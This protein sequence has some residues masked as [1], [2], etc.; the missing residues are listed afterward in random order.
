MSIRNPSATAHGLSR[1]A[2]VSHHRWPAHI[3]EE[4]DRS[5]SDSRRSGRDTSPPSAHLYRSMAGSRPSSRTSL[6]ESDADTD[7]TTST[8]EETAEKH[9]HSRRI[10]RQAPLPPRVPKPPKSRNEVVYEEDVVVD[11]RERR[12]KLRREDTLTQE[13]ERRESRL[14]PRR[15]ELL[16]PEELDGGHRSRPRTV[17]MVYDDDSGE[18]PLPRPRRGE[19]IYEEDAEVPPKYNPFLDG[20]KTPLP[21]PSR[22]TS[23]AP[24]SRHER[25]TNLSKEHRRSSTIDEHHS[26]SHSKQRLSKRYT[27]HQM[28]MMEHNA[29]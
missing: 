29:M 20:P 5:R 9:A 17:D 3:Y 24:S 15:E 13:G 18:E 27:F 11:R 8:S 21:G 16:Y 28:R 1:A 12:P 7:V 4:E 23:R 6:S 2:T 10:P 22:A 26:R 14:K 25:H 19:V